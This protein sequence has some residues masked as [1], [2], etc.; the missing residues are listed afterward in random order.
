MDCGGNQVF[1]SPLPDAWSVP[2]RVEDIVQA[3]GVPLYRVGLASR[4]VHGEAMGSAADWESS[5]AS[6]C[7]FELLERIAVLEAAG[8]ASALM[9]RERTGEPLGGVTRESVFPVS[10]D[11]A[12][13]SFARSSGVAL[14]SDW[15]RA[16]ERACEEL[17]ERD[18]VL[19]SWLGEIVPARLELDPRRLPFSR[20]RSYEWRAFEFPSGAGD[21]LGANVRV[22]GL[23]GFPVTVRAPL[24]YGYAARPSI[25]EALAAAGREAVQQLAFLWDE[26]IPEAMPAV[27]P[28][29]MAHLER[30]QFPEMHAV[31]RG[32]LDGGHARHRRETPAHIDTA[33]PKWVDL[34]PRWLACG[35]KVAKAVCTSAVPLTFGDAPVFAHLPP[36]LRL[37]PIP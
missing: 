35:L 17:V 18:R 1:A 25:Y 20:T 27:G 31:L 23:F 24:V 26:S 3:D 13:W 21:A 34:T 15:G 4:S 8:G 33:G 30:F 37:H 19:R 5:P 6:R 11:P 29:P 9:A 2:E 7:T 16:C 12:V 28:T 14:H 10:P 22:V 32:W 36:E